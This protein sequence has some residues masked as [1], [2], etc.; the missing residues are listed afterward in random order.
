MTI[1]VTGGER[2]GLILDASAEASD[3]P[4]AGQPVH[5]HVHSRREGR[6]D[7]ARF[8]PALPLGH[9]FAGLVPRA[10]PAGTAPHRR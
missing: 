3:V 2:A 4:V 10:L 8:R 5:V 7:R 6:S 9:F 1:G